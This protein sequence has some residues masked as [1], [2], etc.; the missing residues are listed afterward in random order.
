VAVAH[1]AERYGSFVIICLGES[2]L[3]FGVGLGTATDRLTVA[4]V[5]GGGLALLIAVGLW[6][7]YF[8]RFAERAQVRLR[9][10]PDPVLAAADAYSYI[11]LV[12]VAGI[13]IFAGGVRL[14]VH[15]S[16]SAP[17]PISGRLYL[18]GGVALYLLGLAAFRWRIAGERGVLRPLA[19]GA[20]L[21]LAVA[22][23][24]LPA[25]AIGA[26]IAAV[27]IGLCVA[28]SVAEAT[29]RAGSADGGHRDRGRGQDSRDREGE[30]EPISRAPSAR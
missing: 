6:W 15:D 5:V 24:G 22:G 1:F 10:H 13:I 27:L 9:D 4:Q 11:H 16:L 20:V 2:I 28:E 26:V 23:G 30:P 19:A 12:I 8:D 3:A 21:I 18:C 25:W 7:T 29:D 14:V 17:M